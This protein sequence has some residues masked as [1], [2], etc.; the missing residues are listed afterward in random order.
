MGYVSYISVCK[1][2]LKDMTLNLYSISATFAYAKNY[3]YDKSL[4]E[5]N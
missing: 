3:G 4:L 2:G 1:A 5:L